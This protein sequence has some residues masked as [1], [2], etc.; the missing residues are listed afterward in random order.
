MSPHVHPRWE[1][2]NITHITSAL[3]SHLNTKTLQLIHAQNNLIWTDGKTIYKLTTPDNKTQSQINLT[4]AI[5]LLKQ[6]PSYPTPKPLTTKPIVLNLHKHGQWIMTTWK[7]EHF[8][9][10]TPQP[11]TDLNSYH[12]LGQ[13]L[14]QLHNTPIPGL[15][16]YNPLQW[17]EKRVHQINTSELH[18]EF[19]TLQNQYHKTFN[20]NQTPHVS[21]HGD[22]HWHQTAIDDN[23]TLW[24]MDFENS[25][26]GPPQ[27]DLT[28]TAG[29]IRRTGT[30]NP[31]QLQSLHQGY[32]TAPNLTAEQIATQRAIA[33][34]SLK[35]WHIL[36]NK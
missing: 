9:P 15:H 1:H 34:F 6:H 17:A 33:D 3:R 20:P 23:G 18:A 2:I 28:P 11:P 7:H 22:I 30:P 5:A 31:E 16:I 27:I 24:L 21:L 35:T 25:A 4:T 14:Q 36:R 32:G 29:W 13:L 8:Q 26:L 19:T 10:H 12:Q